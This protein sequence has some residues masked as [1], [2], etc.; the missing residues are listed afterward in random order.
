MNSLLK[1]LSLTNKLLLF[2]VVPLVFLLLKILSFILIP[3]VSSMFIALMYLPL[4]RRMK[5]K[6]FP[7]LVSVGIVLVIF[8]LILFTAFVLIKI[9]SLEIIQNKDAFLAQAT[10][11]LD[12]IL[13][14]LQENYGIAN[15]TDANF[16][17]NLA[18]NNS[19]SA[20]LG[21]TFGQIGS[22][23]TMFLMTVFFTVLFLAESI[24]VEKLIATTII[25]TRFA[26]VKTFRRIE[27]DLI[28]FIKVK[29]LVSL[30]TG[31]FT[32]MFCYFFDVSFPIFW[33]LFAFLINFVQMVGSFITIILVSIFGA[34]EID[35]GST[36]LFF[37][38]CVSLTQVLYGSILEPIF[39]GKTF[40]INIVT[41]LVM[42]MLW[43]F[44]WGIPGMILAIP[45]TAFL[46]I[47][48]EQFPKTKILS[49][50][51]SGN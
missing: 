42:L 26:S 44:I 33:G 17:S 4:M 46:K 35:Q 47:I 10:V 2:I 36:L 14:S 22:V 31:I 43:G 49:D 23:L 15:A 24:N 29:V 21:A 48:F 39:M 12:A 37:I 9:S 40:S 30:G 32:G 19:S 6:K 38:I 34:L 7:N 16:L 8:I 28:K 13:L 1:D 18:K 27:K 5:R 3:L 41:V 51:M 50:I 20:G 11:K 45:I 25:K